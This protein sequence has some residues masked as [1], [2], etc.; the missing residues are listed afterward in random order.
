MVCVAFLKKQPELLLILYS[1]Q[2]KRNQNTSY[3][4]AY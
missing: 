3:L 1:I 2:D 4:D